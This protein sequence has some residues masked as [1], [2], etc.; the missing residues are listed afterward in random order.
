MK[1][2]NGLGYIHYE[3]KDNTPMN[4]A[5]KRFLEF[6]KFFIEKGKNIAVTLEVLDYLTTKEEDY[7]NIATI[8]PAFINAVIYNFWA[9]AIIELDG[10][11]YQYNDFSFVNFFN[12]VKSNWN[13]IF[14]GQFYEEIY[15]ENG[16]ETKRVK[17]TR[18]QIFDT[19]AECE[20]IIE[21]QKD[22]LEKVRFFRDK[23]FAH[24]G[25]VKSSEQ[26]KTISIDEL[27]EVFL[28]TQ[29]ILQKLEVFYDRTCTSLK[30][31]NAGDIYQTCWAIKMYKEF[32]TEIA[33][34]YSNKRKEK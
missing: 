9:Q 2:S 29:G 8:S 6:R 16:K 11:Y 22:K 19:I 13:N 5:K 10:F 7:Q 31:M 20:L 17:F 27:K 32:R 24:F 26:D 12:Y 1:N 30:P 15:R 4:D 33:E 28:I 23:I 18:K 21:N 14:T 25:E 3:N 34:M